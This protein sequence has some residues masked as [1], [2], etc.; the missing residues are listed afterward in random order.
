MADF[1]EDLLFGEPEE[2]SNSTDESSSDQEDEEKASEQQQRTASFPASQGVDIT[3]GKSSASFRR[4][5]LQAG[6]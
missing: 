5:Y 1:D 3:S 2:H 6:A 4:I